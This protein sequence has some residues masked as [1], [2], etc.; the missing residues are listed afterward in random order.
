[1]AT[2][3]IYGLR[4]Q[5]SNDAPDG[6]MLGENLA[7]D[8]EDELA[9]IDAAITALTATTSLSL[10]NGWTA[11]G[12]GAPTAVKFGRHVVLTGSITP[13]TTSNGTVVATI[14]SGYRP[15]T[16]LYIQVAAGASGLT[17]VALDIQTN[18]N[19]TIL[20]QS[21][22][23]TYLVLAGITWAVPA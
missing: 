22:T 17:V 3:P 19:I 7:L 23:P 4:Y 14:P 2:T 10:S 13:G 18:G 8:V 11:G 15:Q 20:G 12:F 1:V 5:G 9:R 6:P 21:T 16:E